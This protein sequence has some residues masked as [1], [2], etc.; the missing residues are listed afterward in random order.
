MSDPRDTAG[1]GIACT[2]V[3]S[4]STLLERVE[5]WTYGRKIELCKGLSAEVIT[6]SEAILAHGLSQDEIARWM[7][8]YRRKDFA[9]LK[10][11]YLKR[12]RA[13][14]KTESSSWPEHSDTG[15]SG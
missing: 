14:R 2:R 15:A 3:A 6:P 1:R 9:A 4:R 13:A 10:V 12:G 5:R 7:E 11:G 8:A